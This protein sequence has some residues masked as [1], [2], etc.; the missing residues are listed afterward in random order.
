MKKKYLYILIMNFVIVFPSIRFFNKFL[1]LYFYGFYIILF[2][3]LLIILINKKKV[4]KNILSFPYW[5]YSLLLLTI[6]NYFIYPIIDARKIKVNSGSTGD[7]AIILAAKSFTN[8]G[9]IYD[10]Y[11]NNHTPISP[12][13]AWIIMNIPFTLPHLYF[14]FSP[15]YLFLTLYLLKKYYGN[16]ISNLFFIFIFSSLVTVELFFNG[17]DILPLSLGFLIC[18]I[19]IFEIL[20]KNI[21]LKYI[22]IIS[23]FL[24]IVSTS[25]IIFF[26]VPYLFYFLLKYFHKKNSIIFLLTSSLTFWGFNFYY[27]S[28]NYFYQP[29]HLINKA[30]KLISFPIIIIGILI[31]IFINYLII[32]KFQKK[33]IKN[34]LIIIISIFSIPLIPVSI[35]DLMNQNFNFRTWEGANYFMPIIVLFALLFILNNYKSTIYSQKN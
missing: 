27:Y 17:H 1:N 19:M 26:F 14:L 33:T 4:I 7:D 22:I 9:K 15:F 34:W 3:L 20:K 23:L 18:C 32:N 10:L 16:I 11:I 8:S 13:P 31:F 12:G 5:F 24:G 29:L 21:N 28:I 30:E 35:G 6:S 25:R 2:N